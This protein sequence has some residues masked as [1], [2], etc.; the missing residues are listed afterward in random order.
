MATKLVANEFVAMIELQKLRIRCH[1]AD[2]G[3]I[4]V[5]VSFTNFASIGIAVSAIKGL[6][7]QQGNVVSRFGLRLCMARRW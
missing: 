7:E 6:N 2:W 3:F 5:P 4:R 1:R